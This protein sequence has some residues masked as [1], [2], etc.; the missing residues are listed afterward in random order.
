MQTIKNFTDSNIIGIN[1]KESGKKIERPRKLNAIN[2]NIILKDQQNCLY[3]TQE[4]SITIQF[5]VLLKMWIG[6][7]CCPP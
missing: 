7:F 4:N 1:T 6:C 3:E 5:K 2:I